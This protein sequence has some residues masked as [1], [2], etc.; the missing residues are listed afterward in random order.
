MYGYLRAVTPSISSTE[1]RVRA[2]SCPRC[3]A[4]SEACWFLTS[5]LLTTVL[6]CPNSGA[7]SRYE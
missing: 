5:S 7:S 4:S 2:F 6:L 3:Y 1:N